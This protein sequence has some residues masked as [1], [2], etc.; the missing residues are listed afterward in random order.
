MAA[1]KS[2]QEFMDENAG[3]VS[4]QHFEWAAAADWS[5]T[6]I[7]TVTSLA[8]PS[9]KLD[10]ISSEEDTSEESCEETEDESKSDADTDAEEEDNPLGV[11][12]SQPRNLSRHRSRLIY[13]SDEEVEAK[14]RHSAPTSAAQAKKKNTSLSH[15]R[16]RLLYGSEAE[17]DDEEE[18]DA[19]AAAEYY[20]IEVERSQRVTK[21]RRLRVNE[22]ADFYDTMGELVEFSQPRF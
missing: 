14:P 11:P 3:C 13:D 17:D 20:N 6:K 10:Y 9:E 5:D 7:E 22:T 12:F 15:T 16:R 21:R 2:V 1:T 19:A 8:P 18:A 4:Q